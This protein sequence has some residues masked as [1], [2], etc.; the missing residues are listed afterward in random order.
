VEVTT[1]L[2]KQLSAYFEHMV[3]YNEEY[4]SFMKNY[5][6]WPPPQTIATITQNINI[7]YVPITLLLSK[8]A[9]YTVALQEEKL[10]LSP[11]IGHCALSTWFTQYSKTSTE[12]EIKL[13]QITSATVNYIETKIPAFKVPIFRGGILDR[14]E[15]I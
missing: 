12:N 4:L 10:Y 7:I 15:H 11:G 14:D 2:L 3:I 6:N 5:A 8:I 1:E 9:S 13:G